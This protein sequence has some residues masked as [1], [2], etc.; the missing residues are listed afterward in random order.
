MLRA[1]RYL[2]IDV[3]ADET[4]IVVSLTYGPAEASRLLAEADQ[5]QDGQVSRQEGDAFIS[6]WTDALAAELPI[7]ID[8]TR[9]HAVWNDRAFDP[10]GPIRASSASVEAVAHLVM[11]SGT[12]RITL[13]DRMAIRG[14]DRTDVAIGARD[15]ARMVASGFGTTP[16]SVVRELAFGP[17]RAGSIL[18]AI[19]EVP[20]RGVAF[21][22]WI[23]FGALTLASAAGLWL[24]HRHH[25]RQ[26][27]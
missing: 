15:G 18:T 20:S 22:P 16:N 21:N 12:H 3:S 11:E 19:V 27:R 26:I 23:A 13:R 2:K 4:R 24:F 25:R 8:G 7:E 1:E 14:L 6:R 10:I 9:V 17:Q 5:D